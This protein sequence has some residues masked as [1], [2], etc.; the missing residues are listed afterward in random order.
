MSIDLDICCVQAAYFRIGGA[1][2]LF[3]KIIKLLSARVFIAFCHSFRCTI[4][5]LEIIAEVGSILIKDPLRLRLMALIVII[6]VVVAAVEA[7]ANIR[8]AQRADVFPSYYLGNINLIFTFVAQ[9]HKQENVL[10]VFCYRKP[11]RAEG[12]VR[13]RVW[14]CKKTFYLN[15]VIND[16]GKILKLAA[17]HLFTGEFRQSL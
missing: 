13:V 11:P 8:L 6:R 5:E 4:F 3:K 16:F 17:M 12:M 10:M 1:L 14:R 15:A 2:T 7:A 9:C